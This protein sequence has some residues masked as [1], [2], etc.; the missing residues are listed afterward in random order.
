MSARNPK[1][2]AYI[3]EETRCQVCGTMLTRYPQDYA[4][5]PKCGRAVCRQCW[6]DAWVTRDFSAEACHHFEK[7]HGSSV[8]PVAQRIRGPGMDWPRAIL[9]TVLAAGLVGLLIFL[10]DLLAF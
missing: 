10:W 6:G 2:A 8:S 9:T 7:P 4:A 3:S 5:C 1:P